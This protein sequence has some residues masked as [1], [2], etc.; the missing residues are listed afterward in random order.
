MCFD[1]DTFSRTYS[2]FSLAYW[3]PG[4]L[5]VCCLFIEFT[6]PQM[7]TKPD[8]DDTNDRMKVYKD[9][10]V[11]MAAWHCAACQVELL[12]GERSLSFV[13]RNNTSAGEQIKSFAAI[14][15]HL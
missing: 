11:L 4:L 3:V 5:V 8:R 15:I 6:I 10:W 14:I 2:P 12:P 9:S 7:N 13:N 1:G